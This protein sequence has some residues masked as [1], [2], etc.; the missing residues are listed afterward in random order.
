MKVILLLLFQEIIEGLSNCTLE[1][2]D[3][4][5][6]VTLTLNLVEELGPKGQRGTLV[7]DFHY[8]PSNVKPHKV[9]IESQEYDLPKNNEIA[10]KRLFNKFKVDSLKYSFEVVTADDSALKWT[11]S[12][13]DSTLKVI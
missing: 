2:N 10:Y 6:I 13:N 1:R 3:S 4:C 11:K 5:T 9:T 8:S 12:L 7:V